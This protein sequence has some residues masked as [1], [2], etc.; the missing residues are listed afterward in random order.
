M[1]LQSN[2]LSQPWLLNNH[3]FFC[4]QTGF[5]SRYRFYYLQFLVL[6]PVN[7]SFS[8]LLQ[9][10]RMLKW[11]LHGGKCNTGKWRAQVVLRGLLG[12]CWFPY[13]LYNLLLPYY[14]AGN[15][16][17]NINVVSLSYHWLAMNNSP[18]NPF[19]AIYN[20]N[21]CNKFRRRTRCLRKLVLT[22]TCSWRNSEDE[23]IYDLH[24][25]RN[26]WLLDK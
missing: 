1:R 12:V 2:L 9:F 25:R 7:I 10:M 6:I 19:V 24:D 11:N 16:F 20:G 26:L 14:P 17:P 21:F 23:E 3:S 18:C 22:R 13:Q 5:S 8:C 15:D 4:H